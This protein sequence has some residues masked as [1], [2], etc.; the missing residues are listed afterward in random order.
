MSTIDAITNFTPSQVQE[1]EELVA[2]NEELKVLEAKKKKISDNVKKHMV[3]AKLDKVNVNGSILSLVESTRRTVTKST[4]DEFIAELVYG[5]FPGCKYR[6]LQSP[7][8]Q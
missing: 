1:M 3:D 5:H 8:C 4:K 7:W 6:L 2:I